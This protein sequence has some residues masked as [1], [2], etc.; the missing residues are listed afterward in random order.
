[1]A[2]FRNYIWARVLRWCQRKCKHKYLLA[3]YLEGDIK[4]EE[5]KWCPQ[6]GLIRRNNFEA[7]MPE[8]TWY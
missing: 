4:E 5:I 1:M 3:D 6:C 2:K 7:R 8:P